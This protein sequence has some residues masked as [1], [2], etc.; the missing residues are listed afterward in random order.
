[1]NDLTPVA[2][3][4]PTSASHETD[5]AP[6][7]DTWRARMVCAQ[8]MLRDIPASRLTLSHRIEGDL[9]FRARAETLQAISALAGISEPRLVGVVRRAF[10]IHVLAVETIRTFWSAMPLQDALRPAGAGG[11]K[12]LLDACERADAELVSLREAIHRDHREHV[13]VARAAL[14]PNTEPL[15]AAVALA[16]QL[17]VLSRAMQNGGLLQALPELAPKELETVR[18][19]LLADPDPA[20]RPDRALVDGLVLRTLIE[21]HLNE[22]QPSAATM[23]DEFARRLSA[24]KVAYRHVSHRLQARCADLLR[25]GQRGAA[26]LAVLIQKALFA[27]YLKLAR[28]GEVLYVQVAGW[29]WDDMDDNER[30]SRVEEFGRIAEAQRFRIVYVT[31]G[32][33][34]ELARWSAERGVEIFAD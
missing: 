9:G 13:R 24:D 20:E 22:G 23:P 32:Q 26:D 25:D 15:E 34:R 19:A 8:Q 2:D 3:Q 12:W 29:V 17:D 10:A 21:R 27:T 7:I 1:M 33:K 28:M 18:M 14:I 11:L 5:S 4:H 16:P 31:D 6:V 30:I